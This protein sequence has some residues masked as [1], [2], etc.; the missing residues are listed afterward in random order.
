MSYGKAK[1][2]CNEY[3]NWSTNPGLCGKYAWAKQD[4]PGNENPFLF[5]NIMEANKKE[6]RKKLYKA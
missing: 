1:E 6:K 4:H 5:L 2:P 3:E